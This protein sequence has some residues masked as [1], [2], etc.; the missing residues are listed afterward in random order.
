MKDRNK[1][2]SEKVKTPETFRSLKATLSP[3]VSKNGEVY[4]RLRA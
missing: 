2:L 3:S 1:I 4:M